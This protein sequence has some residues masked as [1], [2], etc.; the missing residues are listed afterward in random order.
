MKTAA[1]FAVSLILIA[2]QHCIASGQTLS[3][4]VNSYCTI[5]AVNS[6]SNIV[7]VDNATGLSA[8]QRVLVYQ[9]KGAAINAANSS[10]Y[11]DLSSL[12]NAGGYEFNTI[13]S[14]SGNDVWLLYPMVNVYDP[15]GQ[16][17]LVTVPSNPTVTVTGTI[18]AQPWDPSTG[19]GGIVALE[20]TSTLNLNADIDV[21]TQGFQGGALVNYPSPPYN[22][23]WFVTVSDY[24][25]GLPASGDNTG[26]K[27]GEGIAAY[28]TNEEYGRGKLANGG[29]GG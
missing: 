23:D 25:Y 4:T 20:A 7:T 14:I 1:R 18:T 3:G 26:A 28:I 16:L 13:C 24:Y 2:L 19:K 15:T 6:V 22:C 17:Q 10:A 29:G 9:A 27:K 21:S 5:T 8:G 12:N 11:G